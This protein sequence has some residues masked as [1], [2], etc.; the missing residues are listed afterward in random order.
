VVSFQDVI[1]TAPEPHPSIRFTD[2]E[3]VPPGGTLKV[4]LAT[5]LHWFHTPFAGPELP[6]KKAVIEESPPAPDCGEVIVTIS[7]TG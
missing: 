6:L 1:E 4:T 7:V 3:N 5:P 2:T